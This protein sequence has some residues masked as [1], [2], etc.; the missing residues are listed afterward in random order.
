MN[1]KTLFLI[2]GFLL[3]FICCSEPSESNPNK[4]PF[5]QIYPE[6]KRLLQENKPKEAEIIYSSYFNTDSLNFDYYELGGDVYWGVQKYKE[7]VTSYRK[8]LT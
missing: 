1:L 7:S 2:S 3:F 8:A 6:I 5:N 4:K